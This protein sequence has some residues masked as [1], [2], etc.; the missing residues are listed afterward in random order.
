MGELAWGP[1]GATIRML[2]LFVCPKLLFTSLG[3]LMLVHMFATKPPLPVLNVDPYG[4]SVSG[5]SA[6]AD[7][8]VQL[9]VAYS[10]TFIGAAIFGGQAYH[11]G[12]Q[13][14]PGEALLDRSPIGRDVPFCDGCPPGKT[15]ALDHCKNSPELTSNVSVLATYAAK[16]AAAGRIDPLEDLA[17]RRVFLYRGKSDSIYKQ[18]SVNTT[19]N[20]FRTFL[21]PESVYFETEVD[22][23]HCLPGINW[24]LCAFEGWF[25]SNSCTFDGAGEALKW[26]YG[27]SALVDGR[28]D[29]SLRLKGLLQ[30]FNQRLYFPADSQD[31]LLAD[32][33]LLFVP[34][35]CTGYD[36]P[37]CKLHVYLHGCFVQLNYHVYTTFGG[38][39]EWAARN[40]IIV[41]Y[42]KMSWHGQ[43]LQQKLGCFDGYG[44]TG[45]D[46]AL[47]AGAQMETVHNMVAGLLNASGAHR[48]HVVV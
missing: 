39:N 2:L 20:F 40:N 22:S 15:I 26:I 7:L 41:L 9:Q 45:R 46:Y 44:Q 23:P 6:G 33:G 19:A 32:E 10:S 47:R 4:V 3:V 24:E 30:P 43:T 1:R 8:A 38:F 31:P 29:G 42:P 27:P 16:E 36:S 17:K 21:P 18:G 5:V 13:F 12:V 34:E 28:D 25:G 37:P 35:G 14:F 48:V 11:C